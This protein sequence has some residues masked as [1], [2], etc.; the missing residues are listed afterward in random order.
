LNQ[1]E[2]YSTGSSNEGPI[3]STIDPNAED[4]RS[5]N[6]PYSSTTPYASTPI[7]PFTN[8]A[9]QGSHSP[10][11]QDGSHWIT[12]PAGPSSQYAQPERCRTDCGKT[13]FKTVF[14]LVNG[15]GWGTKIPKQH[16][17]NVNIIT[18]GTLTFLE[19]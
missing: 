17:Q 5:F 4:L 6:S 19:P 3:Y 18:G 15:S 8:Q 11:E 1:T 16:S 9:L 2:K 10:T 14:P 7:M 12:Q 13:V